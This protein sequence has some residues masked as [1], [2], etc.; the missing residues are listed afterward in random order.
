MR[1]DK[2]AREG[3]IRFVLLRAVGTAVEGGSVAVP[4][5][6]IRQGLASIGGSD[7]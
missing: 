6:L 4:E 7:A 1:H 2:K 5:D 3:A